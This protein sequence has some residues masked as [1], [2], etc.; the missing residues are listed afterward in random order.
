MTENWKCSAHQ[1][2][3]LAKPLIFTDNCGQ[4]SVSFNLLSNLL[5]VSLMMKNSVNNLIINLWFYAFWRQCQIKHYLDVFFHQEK[6][7]TPKVFE[8]CEESGSDYKNF[9]PAINEGT[10]TILKGYR[11]KL[12]SQRWGTFVGTW[13]FLFKI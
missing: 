12:W 10:P 13:R 5:C 6:V 1:S 9:I 7:K 2:E 11:D 4:F 3:M 8:E